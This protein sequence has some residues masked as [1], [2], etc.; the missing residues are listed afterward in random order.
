MIRDRVQ[1]L[2]SGL[3]EH[4]KRLAMKK[5]GKVAFKYVFYDAGNEESNVFLDL[6]RWIRSIGLIGISTWRSNSNNLIL[7]DWPLGSRLSTS[8]PL[9]IPLTLPPLTPT[10]EEK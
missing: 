3:K 8:I 9:P 5:S 4:K 10:K 6:Q 1:K 2:E 7:R